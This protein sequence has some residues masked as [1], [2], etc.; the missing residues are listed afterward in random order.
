MYLVDRRDGK[1]K[2][3]IELS[4]GITHAHTIYRPLSTLSEEELKQLD[5]LTQKLALPE[6]ESDAEPAQ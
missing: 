5:T 3:A 2:T 6:G 1:P 4:G